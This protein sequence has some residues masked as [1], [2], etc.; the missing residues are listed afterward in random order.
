MAAPTKPVLPVAPR[1]SEPSTFQERADKRD[2]LPH[3]T[4]VDYI[5][6]SNGFTQEQAEVTLAAAI[7]NNIPA[8][9][10]SS[11]AGDLIAVNAAGDAI[12]GVSPVT[13]RAIATEAQATAGTSNSVEMSPLRVNDVIETLEVETLGYA[14]VKRT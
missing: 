11:I 10:L 9:T 8:A 6:E 2:C 5:A 4:L 3:D 1:S 12:E 13:Q 14:V 7:I